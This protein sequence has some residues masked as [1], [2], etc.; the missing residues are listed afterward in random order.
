MYGY[1]CLSWNTNIIFQFIEYLFDLK[2]LNNW[3]HLF[4]NHNVGYEINFNE[5]GKLFWHTYAGDAYFLLKMSL[6]ICILINGRHDMYHVILLD[7]MRVILEYIVKCNKICSSLIVWI[8]QKIYMDDK[9][10][11]ILILPPPPL[12]V[13]FQ[14]AGISWSVL[15]CGI[16]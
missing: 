2:R 6:L 4:L 1:S 3:K 14:N 16:S 12:P 15:L 9:D 7:Q 10:I 5:V 11:S 8:V 13:L